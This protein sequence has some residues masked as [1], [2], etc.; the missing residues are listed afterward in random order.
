M[1]GPLTAML[2]LV[3]V[4]VAGPVTLVAALWISPYEDQSLSIV[5]AYLPNL[6]VFGLLFGMG[7][8][9]RAFNIFAVLGDSPLAARSTDSRPA[10]S[11]RCSS[12]GGL[13]LW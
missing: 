5:L 8:P 1:A 12:G 10:C 2:Y 6:A 7:V 9:A 13:R 4:A 3:A 11:A